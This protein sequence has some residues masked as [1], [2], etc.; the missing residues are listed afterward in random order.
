MQPQ[1]YLAGSLDLIIE[2]E[3]HSG[4]GKGDQKQ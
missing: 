3:N 4:R 2:G 1:A